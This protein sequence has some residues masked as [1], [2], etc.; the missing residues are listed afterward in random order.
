MDLTTIEKEALIVLGENLSL[1]QFT[2]KA[3]KNTLNALCFKGLVLSPTH[4]NSKMW[5]LTDEGRVMYKSIS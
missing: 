2:T 5:E 1:P 4:T 3:R